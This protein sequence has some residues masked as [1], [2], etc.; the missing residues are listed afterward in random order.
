VGDAV[1]GDS[2]SVRPNTSIPRRAGAGTWPHVP[3]SEENQ[4]G[5]PAAYP[6]A[7]APTR[8]GLA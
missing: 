1:A 3:L 6:R 7:M 5:T 4:H 2:V 8:R